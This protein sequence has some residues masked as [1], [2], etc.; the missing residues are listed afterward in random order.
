MYHVDP[1]IV[2]LVAADGL[3]RPCPDRDIPDVTH[4]LFLDGGVV[5]S[6]LVEEWGAEQ[7]ALAAKDAE[8]TKKEQMRGSLRAALVPLKGKKPAQ[9]GLPE[10]R[11]LLAVLLEEKGLLDG[12][13]AVR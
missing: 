7:V 11:D 12:D 9:W 10:I 6:C 1:A 13:G 2:A 5:R 3:A 4:M 8:R